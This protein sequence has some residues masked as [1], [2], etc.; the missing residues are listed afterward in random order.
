[1]GRHP[2]GIFLPGTSKQSIVGHGHQILSQADQQQTT[3]HFCTDPGGLAPLIV[4][5]IIRPPN[6]PHTS[7]SGVATA[8]E[9]RLFVEGSARSCSPMPSLII[10]HQAMGAS[11]HWLYQLIV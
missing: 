8:C 5:H 3:R 10:L 7:H 11:P 2:S 9:G 1:M 4:L 6:R